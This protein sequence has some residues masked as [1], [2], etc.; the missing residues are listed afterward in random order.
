MRLGN[1]LDLEAGPTYH[2]I[3]SRDVFLHIDDKKR[4]FSN[5]KKALLPGGKLLFTDYCC[6]TKPW[7]ND[8]AAYVSHRGYQLNTVAEYT[9]ILEDAG[10]HIT[11]AEDATDRFID[12]LKAELKKIATL[13]FTRSEITLLADS[14]QSKID[15]ANQGDQRWGIFQAQL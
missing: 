13:E 8:F 6:G 5:I 12:I 14:W 9:Q 7:S 15:R 10:F 3:F 1:C 2:G 11:R 4:L